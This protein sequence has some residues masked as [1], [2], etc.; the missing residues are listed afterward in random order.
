MDSRASCYIAQAL[1]DFCH[2]LLCR[3]LRRDAAQMRLKQ[4]CAQ[5][6]LRLIYARKKKKKLVERARKRQ[7]MVTDLA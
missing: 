4:S 7:D 1:A 3:W 6:I 2:S 5:T